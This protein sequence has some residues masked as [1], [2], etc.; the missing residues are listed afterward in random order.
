MKSQF[1]SL[2]TAALFLAGPASGQPAPPPGLLDKISASHMKGHVSFLASDLLEG[3]DTPSKGL[4]IAAEYIAAHFRALGLE[5]GGDDGYFQKAPFALVRQ[6]MDGFEMT[7]IVNGQ[8]IPVPKE[9][10]MVSASAAADLSSL[11][12]IKL[13]LGDKEA[14][15]NAVA[16]GLAN[17]ALLLTMPNFAAMSEEERETAFQTAMAARQKLLTAKPALALSLGGGGVGGGGGAARPRLREVS[18]A[19]E[20]EPPTVTI[21][22]EAAMKALRELPAGA[23]ASVSVK[24]PAP[25]EEKIALRNVIG[26]LRG[27]DPKL[28]DEYILV[29]A[30]Y[31]HT[32]VRAQ[33]EGDRINNGANDDASG[34]A[35]VL[36]MAAAFVHSG[37]KP[38]RTIVF[39]TYFGEEKG[40][41]GSRYYGR[42]PRF[43]LAKTVAN[44]NLEHMGRTDDNE[45]STAGKLTM[46]GFDFTDM[47]D[48]FRM[49]GEMTGVVAYKHEKNSD[50][51]F[52]RSDNQ[53]LADAGIP[54]HTFCAAFIF[55]DYHRP[56]D[57][58]D[59]IDYDNMAKVLRTATLMTWMISENPERP[60][61]NAAN[62]KTAKYVEAAKKLHATA[63]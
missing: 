48:T 62:P 32:G 51:F 59:K 40:L 1:F 3:R 35:C 22:D 60:K 53:A 31:D 15:D 26:V 28:A 49:A 45:G 17:K 14:V 20:V 4:E 38:K 56:G 41:L 33:G 34:T 63:P 39:M 2:A 27:S 57:H 36:D 46:T 44:L 58:W 16:Q 18:P 50:S 47:G 11:P 6:P 25:Q 23:T 52:G 61:W 21:S 30:H 29:T 24:I 19:G 5:P 7:I 12:I 55:P 54:A 43:P 10:A 9:R 13:A 37:V 8:T 42:N